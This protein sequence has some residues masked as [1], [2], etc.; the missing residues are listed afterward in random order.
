MNRKQK[1][2][3]IKTIKQ[4]KRQKTKG[5]FGLQPRNLDYRLKKKNK[6]KN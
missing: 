1:R 3:F 2:A 5:A 6:D 4:S